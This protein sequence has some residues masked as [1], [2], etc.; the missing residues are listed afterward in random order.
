MTFIDQHAD[1]F[2]VDPICRV[3]TE[4]GRPISTSTYCAAKNRPPSARAL[5]DAELDT[6]IQRIHAANYGVY[7]VRKV[8]RQLLREGHRVARCTVGRRMRALG[9]QGVRRGKKV[10]TMP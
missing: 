3:L 1:V 10:R 8:W 2:G 4:H 9:L 6:H 5:R 7:G